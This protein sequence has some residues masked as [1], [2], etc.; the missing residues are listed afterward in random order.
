MKYYKAI[1]L[2]KDNSR[3]KNSVFVGDNEIINQKFHSIEAMIIAANEDGTSLRP[4]NYDKNFGWE[5]SM[6]SG[7]FG[8]HKEVLPLEWLKQNNYLSQMVEEDSVGKIYYAK[9]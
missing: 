1:P 5:F 6:Y 2:W 8:M 3:K 9:T 4:A 7:W